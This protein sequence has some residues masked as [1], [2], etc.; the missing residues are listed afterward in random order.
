MGKQNAPSFV[1]CR[2]KQKGKRVEGKSKTR[3][4]RNEP[5]PINSKEYI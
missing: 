5:K 2:D 4:K 3:N 1:I